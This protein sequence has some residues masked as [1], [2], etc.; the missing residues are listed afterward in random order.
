LRDVV[1]DGDAHGAPG[2]ELGRPRSAAAA[3]PRKQRTDIGDIAWK[4]DTFSR[5]AEAV[6]QAGKIDELNHNGI[7]AHRWRGE[8]KTPVRKA[9]AP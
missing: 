6:A 3:Q 2:R 7:L 5:G 9:P 4:R 1:I 8:T